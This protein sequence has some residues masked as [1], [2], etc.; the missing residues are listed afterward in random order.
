MSTFVLIPGGWH[1]GWYF[2]QIAES[3]RRDGHSAIPVT[4]TGL[5][6]RGHLRTAATNLDTHIQDVVSVLEAE[7]VDDAVLV[8]HSYAGMVITG[9]AARVPGRIRRLVYS[10]AYV[11]A[12]GDSCFD[13]TTAAFRELFLQGARADGHSVAP[14][15][16]LNPRTTAHPLASFLQKIQLDGPPQVE[17]KDYIYLSGWP[18]TPFTEV[19]QRLSG[20]PGWHVHTLPTG[21]N[22]AAE[23][24]EAFVRILEEGKL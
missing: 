19:Y 12:D 3:L 22:V 4:L 2:Q 5:G 11:P 16:G 1:G 21:H 6:D 24:P 8:G 14:P 23:A 17:R 9:A 7:D 15:P 20:D 10:D 18:D 13:L